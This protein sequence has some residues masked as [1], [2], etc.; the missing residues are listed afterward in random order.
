[1]GLAAMVGATYLLVV[2]GLGRVPKGGERSVLA[3]SMIAAAVAAVLASPVRRRLEEIANQR[4]YGERHAPDEALRGFGLRMSRSV[5]MD[6]LLLQLAESLKKTMALQAAEIWTGNDGVIDRSVSVPDRP[7][8][9]IV[10]AGEELGVA[11]R[12]RVQGNAWLQVWLP[13]LL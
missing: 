1:V 8:R 6:E 9:R 5:P 12:A 13:S 2:A 3:L 11:A 4:V 10:L 7:V